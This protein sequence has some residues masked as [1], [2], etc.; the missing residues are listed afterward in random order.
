MP[1]Y[2]YK[3]DGCEHTWEEFHSM[4]AEPTKK[5]P[6]CGKK[7]A[8]RLIG[9]GGGLIFKGTG[10]YQ[11]DYRSDSYKKSADADKAPS[12][13]TDPKASTDSSKKS[14]SKTNSSE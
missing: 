3:C 4:T 12:A 11:T 2:D 6:T 5:C 9:A 14:E 10:F 1:T 7:K 13:N 8:K